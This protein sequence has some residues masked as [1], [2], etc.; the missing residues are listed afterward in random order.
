[1]KPSSL[2]TYRV[3]AIDP[4]SRGFG[5]AVME[6]PF[7]LIDFGLKIPTKAKGNDGKRLKKVEA[8]IN[9]YQPDVLVAEDS[10]AKECRRKPRTRKM[11]H[12]IQ[13][14]VAGRNIAFVRLSWPAVQRIVT[15]RPTSTKYT[16]A[17]KIA[18]QFQE[19]ESYLPALR[20]PWM[21]EDETMNIF[22]A[23]ALALAML[24]IRE[25]QLTVQAQAISQN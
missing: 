22:D 8:M 6:E 11:L 14:L 17:T 23:T 13:K 10:Q 1:M 21:S 7:Q 18:Q 9:R 19:L 24:L 15:E 2:A 20:K 25:K 5:F 12:D 4:Y 16:V 3:L